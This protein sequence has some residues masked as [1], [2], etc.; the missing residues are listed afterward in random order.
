MRHQENFQA[1][2]RFPP[3]HHPTKTH[4]P[5][6]LLCCESRV[7]SHNRSARTRS[8]QPRGQDY[9]RASRPQCFAAEDTLLLLRRNKTTLRLKEPAAFCY[10]EARRGRNLYLR[11]PALHSGKTTRPETEQPPPRPQETKRRGP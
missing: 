2:L 7:C 3:R 1:L 5:Q 11:A 6:K 4:T 10:Y 8:H 9:A